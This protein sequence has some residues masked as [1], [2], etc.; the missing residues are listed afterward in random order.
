MY[1][2]ARFLISGDKGLVVE[3]G[4]EISEAV[5]RRVRNLYL[6]V[7]KCK[8]EGV[9][10][11]VPTYRSLMIQYNPMETDMDSLRIRLSEIEESLDG[12]EL[13]NPKIIEIPTIY[14]GAFGEDLSFVAEHNGISEDEVIKIHSSVDY[15]I[16][17]LGFSPGFPYLGGMNE[18][19][20]T[21]RLKTP[22]TKIPAGSVGIAGKQTGIYPMESPGGWQLIGRTPLKLYDPSRSTP[23]LLQAG[24]YLRFVPVDKSEYDRIKELVESNKYEVKLVTE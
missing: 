23:V 16:Y 4:N 6:A 13:P 5:N 18:K 21:P 11:M 3:F 12:I 24:D 15:R 14:G 17:M 9:L 10:E 2:K 22:R 8:P 7:Q 19:I 1:E 20:E